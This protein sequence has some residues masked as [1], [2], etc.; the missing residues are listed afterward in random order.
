MFFYIMILIYFII[1]K[2]VILFRF[3]FDG[4]CTYTGVFVYIVI[5]WIYSIIRIICFQI[6]IIFYL[7][8]IRSILIF[9]FFIIFMKIKYNFGIYFIVI[10]VMKFKFNSNKICIIFFILYFRKNYILSLHN[11]HHRCFL[12]HQN[13]HFNKDNIYKKY[14]IYNYFLF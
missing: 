2:Y 12:F 8:G 6:R 1:T 13:I 10:I 5:V 9:V 4:I 14:K 7:I 11:R 3:F